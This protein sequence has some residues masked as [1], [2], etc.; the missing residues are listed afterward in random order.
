MELVVWHLCFARTATPSSVVWVHALIDYIIP[1]NS[2][3]HY[4]SVIS[5]PPHASPATLKGLHGIPQLTTKTQTCE[6]VICKSQNSI[7]V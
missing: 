3:N 1:T 4:P 6:E 2:L 5:K 7:E